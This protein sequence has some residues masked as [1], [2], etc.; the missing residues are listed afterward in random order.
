M[1]KQI[2]LIGAGRIGTIHAGNIAA[3]PGLELSLVVDVNS[4]AAAEALRTR[5]T[6][7]LD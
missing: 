7:C 4:D 5:S 1:A 3:Q 6:V 2:A